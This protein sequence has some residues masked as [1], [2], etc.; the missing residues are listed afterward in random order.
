MPEIIR[1]PGLIDVHV[2][3]RDPGQTQKEDFT[4]GT[5]AA[6]AGGFT[7]VVDMPNN[8]EPIVSVERIKNKIDIASKKAVS[9]IGF[10]YGS[11]GDNLESFAEA[12]QYAVGLKLYLNQTTGG[13]LLDAKHLQKIYA[14]W[15]KEKV[16][17]L[18]VEED[19]IDVAI[20]SLKGIKR[21]IHVCHMPSKIILEKIIA[22]K[23]AGYPVTCG[24]CAHHLFLTEENVQ[25]LDVYG[26]MLPSLK[27]KEDQ[28]Y[29]WEHLDDIDIFESD[30][31]PHTKEE[32][33]AG[34]FGVPGLETTL[35][36]LLTAEK[37]GRITREQIKEKCHTAPARIF[38]IP[39]DDSTY[40]EVSMED[41]VL[42]NNDLHTKCG[43]SPF[44]GMKLTGKVVKTV[45]RGETVFEDGKIL[46]KAGSGNV[47][48][49]H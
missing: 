32:K 44:A 45:L 27:T 3:L 37:Q 5:S 18:H 26:K 23:K 6:L 17:L 33:E 29:L 22:A 39:T 20:E 43:W 7:T 1:L 13:Y 41:Y 46:A 47:L 28:D 24:V 40:V 2:H 25:D 9:D 48:N 15:P 49:S 14:A 42:S 8:A 11:L 12:A 16:V 10:H 36:L 21:P 31:A 34:A 38:N 4:T 30:H 19:L 35:P